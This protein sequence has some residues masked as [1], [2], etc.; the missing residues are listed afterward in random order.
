MELRIIQPEEDRTNYFERVCGFLQGKVKG[1]K[2]VL[3]SRFDALLTEFAMSL[4]PLSDTK[5]AVYD[6]KTKTL[7]IR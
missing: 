2:E 4:A 6:A 1:N 3:E 5:K 7:T